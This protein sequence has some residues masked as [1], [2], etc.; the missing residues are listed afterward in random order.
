MP[1]SHHD[2]DGA[3][4]DLDPAREW[5]RS[6]GV[7]SD[8]VC[9]LM[10][11]YMMNHEFSRRDTVTLILSGR[12]IEYLNSPLVHLIRSPVGAR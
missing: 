11:E 1:W 10:V 2:S 9:E 7:A 12:L 8:A 3:G 6:S 4:A 5:W